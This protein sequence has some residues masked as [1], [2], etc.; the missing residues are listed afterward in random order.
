VLGLAPTG[1]E[2]LP[3][4][5]LR[6]GLAE[7]IAA[8]R[9]PKL[10]TP[11]YDF[12]RDAETKTLNARSIAAWSKTL[13]DALEESLERNEFPVVLGGD[14]SILLGSALAL[15]RRGRYGLLFIDG[16]A[17]FYQPEVNPNGQAASMELAFATGYGPQLLTDLEGRAPLVRPDDVFAFGFRDGEEQ[18]QYG[19]QPLPAQLRAYEL[20]EV[21][22]LGVEPAARTAVAHVARE[23]LDGFFIHVDADVLDD[24][25]MPAVDYRLPG[26]L[27]LRE[28]R[29]VL[30]HALASGRAVGLEVAIYN[31][32]LDPSG[33]AG[34]A[35]ASLL[36][37]ALGTSA[38]GA[39]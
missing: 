5:L 8:R 32:A 19:S 7:G 33:A 39:P 18:R 3:E 15:R 16:H 23:E 37:G 22:K 11:D 25:V 14:C 24:A 4:V 13:A 38:P 35:L 1:V 10:P 31:P 17:D 36:I 9:G 27:Q 2:R 29:F 12:E 21:R 34:R 26:G 6:N 28:L 20:A 30:A